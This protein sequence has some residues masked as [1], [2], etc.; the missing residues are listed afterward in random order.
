MKKTILFLAVLIITLSGCGNKQLMDAPA[1]DGN[2]YY[3]NRDL[4]FSL[5]LPP[6]FEYYQIQRNS[7]DEYTDIEV[8]VP[9]SDTSYPQEVSGYAKPIVIRMFDSDYWG[10]SKEEERNIYQKIG[11]KGNF[12]YTIRFWD[13]PSSDWQDKWSEEMKNKIIEDF[14]NL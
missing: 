10:N 4:G 5:I 9:T 3:Q 13:S 8:F 14:K 6:E 7:T 12:I 1:E 2:Y 11:A